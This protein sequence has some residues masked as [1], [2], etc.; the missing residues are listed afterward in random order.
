MC[1]TRE[2]IESKWTNIWAQLWAEA[3]WQS[4]LE[5]SQDS[6]QLVPDNWSVVIQEWGPSLGK[7]AH[8]QV[9]PPSVHTKGLSLLSEP[10]LTSLPTSVSS[11][12]MK[13]CL[14]CLFAWGRC[15][16][17]QAV[18][19]LQAQLGSVS[20]VC[21][22]MCQC[23]TEV[24]RLKQLCGVASFNWDKC[25]QLSWAMPAK[26]FFFKLGC[27]L[28][29][30]RELKSP[31]ILRAGVRVCRSCFLLLQKGTL[32]CHLQ[33]FTSCWGDF[34][35]LPPGGALHWSR[36]VHVLEPNSLVLWGL[37]DGE[38]SPTMAHYSTASP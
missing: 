34:K 5:S 36:S 27:P 3:F 24:L 15:G 14:S 26:S 19:P 2:L 32:L 37:G 16:L 1:C 17:G 38:R 22:S 18:S 7:S 6:S 28:P 25:E 9:V 4:T 8:S 29:T 31:S 33:P 20:A 30:W 35:G 13:P 11:S 23:V 10:A 12:F 21:T